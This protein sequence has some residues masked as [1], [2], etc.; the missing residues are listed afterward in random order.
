MGKGPDMVGIKQRGLVQLKCCIGE[1]KRG[2]G[3][4][5]AKEKSITFPVV[6][7]QER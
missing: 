6:L 3:E 4:W 7:K 5:C 2:D 1:R